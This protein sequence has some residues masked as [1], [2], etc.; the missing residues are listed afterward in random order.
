[1]RSSASVTFH[2]KEEICILTSASFATQK[3]PLTK[4]M[5]AEWRRNPN[6]A[7]KSNQNLIWAARSKWNLSLR[8]LAV[9]LIVIQRFSAS[10]SSSRLACNCAHTFIYFRAGWNNHPFQNQKERTIEEG[11]LPWYFLAVA[12]Q[13]TYLQLMTIFCDRMSLDLRGTK[14]LFEGNML[15][16]EAT[17]ETL[18][19]ENGDEI[20]AMLQQI[21]GDR[22]W[23]EINLFCT[24]A[25]ATNAKKIATNAKTTATYATTTT[26]A[27]QCA[28][29]LWHLPSRALMANKI[30]LVTRTKLALSPWVSK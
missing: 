11:A 21:G 6:R 28:I 1:M 25:T 4:W 18:G 14:F 30:R 15:V 13:L 27:T 8:L 29:H 10:R 20:D 26:T 7:T 12:V 9:L 16:P 23:F 24:A 22:V 5:Q 3:T 19:M 2:Y 17:A